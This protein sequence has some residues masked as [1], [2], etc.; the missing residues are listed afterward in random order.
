MAVSRGQLIQGVR[1]FSTHMPELQNH[2]ITYKNNFK[3]LPK[4]FM[5]Q[6]QQVFNDDP[7]K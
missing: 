7:T 6:Y 3:Q 5:F 4:E 2:Q 1:K